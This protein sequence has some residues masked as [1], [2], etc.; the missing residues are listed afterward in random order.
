MLVRVDVTGL[1]DG[2][3]RQQGLSVPDWARRAGLGRSTLYRYLDG[4][5]DPGITTLDDLLAVVGMHA[6]V[7]VEPLSD[8]AAG[9]ALVSMLTA[10]DEP[11]MSPQAA[12]WV[13]RLDRIRADDPADAARLAGSVASVLRRPDAVG[14]TATGWDVDRLV[15]AGVASRADWALSGWAAL[16]A[17]G[18]DVEAVTV[19]HSAAPRTV[20]HLLADTFT[21]VTLAEADVVVVPASEG[22]L[23]SA[24]HVE[25]V[26]LVSPTQ[27]YVDAVGLDG[28]AAEIALHALQER[29]RVR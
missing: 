22:V 25:D 24:T 2:L 21:T 3:R 6:Q 4:S 11:P 7:T 17:M 15:S 8:P 5:Q 29:L 1:L 14:L 23:E 20:V 13:E 26:R 28:A 9:A 27:A 18:H 10:P 12:R 16:D 19:F